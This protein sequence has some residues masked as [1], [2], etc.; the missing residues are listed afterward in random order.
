MVRRSPSTASGSLAR[1]GRTGLALVVVVLALVGCGRKDAPLPPVIRVAET[2][3]DLAVVQEGGEAVLQ[4]S[5]PAMTTAGGPL[6]DVE[7]IEV[8]RVAVPTGQ[9]PEGT[10]AKD[11]ELRA[12]LLEARGE[13]I[14]TLEG[15]ALEEATRGSGLEVRDDLGWWFA[16]REDAREGQVVWYGV[17]TV[18][19]GA[20]VSR[21][22]NVARLV[23]QAP[24][25]PPGEL[26]ATPGP[27][28]ITL[29]WQADSVLVERS[30]DG[31][32][33]S[34]ITPEPVRDRS[35][36]DTAA[37]LG[38]TWWYRLRGV[39]SPDGEGLVRGPAGEPRRVPYPDVYPP[40]PPDDLV[41]LPEADR[42]RLRWQPVS[43]AVSYA[44]A[45]RPEG[46]SWSE[47]A[48]SLTATAFVDTEPVGGAVTYAV[49]AVDDVGNRSEEALCTAVV[50][51][52][53]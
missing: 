16:M 9:E 41:C 13:R 6:P 22:S 40:P 46:G 2:T 20:R 47:L 49:R 18:C 36:T 8:W 19:C 26:T 10:S 21:F 14:R 45:R 23:P 52:A 12:S 33:W 37:E 24:P 29:S 3:R 51:R 50:A 42:V 38:Q 5:W 28:G 48:P 31:E 32:Q 27:H 11:Q 4:W 43:G 1:V 17:R 53:P 39:R 44:V 7:K 30:D 25:P 34:Q 35:F 15:P